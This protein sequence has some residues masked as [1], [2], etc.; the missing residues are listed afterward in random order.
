MVRQTP[1]K[2]RR[3]VSGLGFFGVSGRPATAI[4]LSIPQEGKSLEEAQPLKRPPNQGAKAQGHAKL[5]VH[6]KAVPAQPVP[7][8]WQLQRHKECLKQLP[9]GEVSGPP[10]PALRAAQKRE[11]RYQHRVQRETVH[12]SEAQLDPARHPRSGDRHRRRVRKAE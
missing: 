11:A 12:W 5:L 8:L 1:R 6:A 10:R 4:C 2:A 7:S 3:P 9:W